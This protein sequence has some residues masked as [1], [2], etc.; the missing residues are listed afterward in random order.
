MKKLRN[1]TNDNNKSA[2]FFNDFRKNLQE[3]QETPKCSFLE[4]FR[5]SLRDYEANL[6]KTDA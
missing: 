3:V 5:K 6:S 2:G 1:T 4:A